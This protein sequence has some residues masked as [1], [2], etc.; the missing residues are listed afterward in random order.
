MNLKELWQAA[1]GEIELGISKANFI[2][3]FKN[4]EI[5]SKKN[6][7]VIVNVPNGFTKEWLENKYNKL[8]FRALRNI[9]QDIKEVQFII[10]TPL[11]LKPFI[12]QRKELPKTPPEEQLG[13][14]E[15]NVD[16]ETNLNPKYTFDNFIIGSFNELAQAAA[17]A[18]TKHLG[19]LYNPLF[20][21]GGVGLGKTHLLQAIGNELN[22]K[23]PL[24]KIKYLSSEKYMSELVDA[25]SKKGMES[26]KPKYRKIDVLIIDD[27][28][29]IAGKE[30]TQEEFFHT[31]NAL[32]QKNKQIIIS[33]DRPP[34][35]IPT[36]EERLSSRF[37]GGM[38]A[39]I[40]YPDIETRIAI[41]K[42]KAKENKLEISDEVI[43]YVA[44]HVQKNIRELE[45]ALN[46]I[47]AA[48]KITE[49][50]PDVDK[51]KKILSG[52]ISK[53]KKLTNFKDIIK[54]V[55]EFY[56]INTNDL[57][58]K[59]RRKEI[60]RPRQISM[61]LIRKELNGSFPYIGEKLGGRDHTT[62]MYSYE[63]IN[64]DMEN[65]EA[66]QQEINLIKERIYN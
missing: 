55:A 35:A 31:F 39:D 38:I 9:S 12:K 7:V 64:K 51:A 19:T 60:V 11:P 6:G 52:I 10:G 46:R 17:R 43:Y 50:A 61:Y 58:N 32:Y 27:I 41:L 25:I 22:K 23:H 4:T 13:F 57:I 47:I 65:N 3:W 30:K 8:I 37:E 18:V 49:S 29:F 5:S 14:E 26:F 45:G 20:I 34:K 40:S 62:A 44:S 63:K 42:N 1:L 53:P 24:K 28:Q 15:F 33:S 2:T 66:L 16:K 56:D 21:Y 54:A 36:I 59:C 48:C